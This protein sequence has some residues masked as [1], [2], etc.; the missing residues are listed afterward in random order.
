MKNKPFPLDL[1]K[2][3][4][5]LMS[6]GMSPTFLIAWILPMMIV[7]IPGLFIGF[8]FFLLPL[9]LLP[10]LLSG[11]YY[12]TTESLYW[13]PTLRALKKVQLTNVKPLSIEVG[14]FTKSLYIKDDYKLS[15]RFISKL[16]KL[17]GALI[18]YSDN[19]I[20]NCMKTAMS[21]GYSNQS[22][23]IKISKST[24]SKGFA[25]QIGTGIYTPEYV[26][27]IPSTPQTNVNEVGLVITLSFI[28]VRRF[29]VQTSFPIF[30]LLSSLQ[31]HETNHE[32]MS[33]I[34]DYL[35]SNY[36]GI[37]KFNTEVE[38]VK[39]MKTSKVITNEG[40]FTITV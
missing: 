40:T 36:S 10:Y 3:E 19:Y 11:K 16:D 2:D 34:I 15:L 7:T 5:I 22:Q 32:D 8:G 24:F 4:Y 37:K 1:A 21:R 31:E 38:I 12:L 27:F 28:G 6:G 26:A 30:E 25:S 23:N 35:V 39:S 9:T 14:V 20:R 33:K 13:K 18:F 17:W 29:K